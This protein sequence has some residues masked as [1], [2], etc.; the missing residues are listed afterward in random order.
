MVEIVDVAMGKIL[1]LEVLNI[2]VGGAHDINVTCPDKKGKEVF[3]VRFPHCFAFA[4]G[5]GGIGVG[6]GF[7]RV[8][9]VLWLWEVVVVVAVLCGGK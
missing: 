6:V 2:Y 4:F 3:F 5:L 8:L 7:W 1:L 9:C